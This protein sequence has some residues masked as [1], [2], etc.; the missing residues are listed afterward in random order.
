MRQIALSRKY[1]FKSSLPCV[2]ICI[3]TDKYT[4]VTTETTNTQNI[5]PE[6]KNNCSVKSMNLSN[7]TAKDRSS[8]F[9]HESRGK[10]SIHNLTTCYII[11]SIASTR[12]KAMNYIEMK[13]KNT[14]MLY[15]EFF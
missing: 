15:C 13:R 2:I 9:H 4:V 14:L 1:I 7:S 11:F 3:S 10:G 12:R 8:I 5:L 6:V